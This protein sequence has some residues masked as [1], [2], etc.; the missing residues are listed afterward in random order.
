MLTRS[1]SETL[2]Q[3][4]SRVPD[5]RQTKPLNRLLQN[6]GGGGTVICCSSGILVKVRDMALRV[7]GHHLCCVFCYVGS[8]AQTARDYFGVDNAIPELVGRLRRE[9]DQTIEVAD[10]FDDVCVVCPLYTGDG[11]GRD[12]D[13][14]AQNEKLR[15]WD[16]QIVSRLGLRAGDRLPF[17]TIVKRIERN[18]PDIGE[19]CTN[20][21]SS[22]PNGFRTFKEGLAKGL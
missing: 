15:E 18:I 20:C 1:P 21:T 6:T 7:R 5:T 19:I 9:P 22:K 3:P 17:T 11:C 14:L 10:D 13:G 2:K 16:R 4:A 8:G 12:V